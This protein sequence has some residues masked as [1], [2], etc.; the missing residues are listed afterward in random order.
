MKTVHVEASTAYDILIGPGLIDRCGQLIL[1]VVEPCK[2]ALVTDDL[3]AALYGDRVERALASAGFEVH[4]CT[5]PNGEPSKNLE[6]LCGLLERF[7]DL[8][9]VR[10]DLIVCLGGGVVGDMGAFAA[11]VYGRGTRFVQIATTLLAAVDS[12]VGGKTAVNLRA[13][14]NMAG[15]FAQPSRVLIDTDVMRT[16]PGALVADGAAEVIKYGVLSDPALLDLAADGQLMDQIEDVIERCVTIKRAFVQDDEFDRGQRQLLNLG[17]TIGH[18]IELYS[19]YTV[20]HGRAVGMGLFA[21]AKAARALGH[22]ESDCVPPIERALRACGLDVECPY[23]ADA[24]LR[25][26]LMDKKRT[27]SEITLAVPVR[28]GDC[29]LMK[30]PVAALTDWVWAG[31]IT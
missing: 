20:Q 25:G 7:G 3:V 18:A 17:H 4:R 16:L 23:S 6:T 19:G 13:A 28:I 8:G 31:G 14:K 30:V 1:D 11:A 10:S 2:V 22:S 26:M 21:I 24:I 12:S 5:F 15:T 27:G 29:R 9:L